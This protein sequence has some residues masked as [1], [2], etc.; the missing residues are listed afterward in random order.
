MKKIKDFIIKNK[1]YIIAFLFMLVI[2]F[3]TPLNGDDWPNYNP[4]TSLKWALSDAIRSYLTYESRIASRFLINILCYNK[5]IWNILNALA[6]S[7]IYWSLTKLFSV[8]NSK[9]YKMFFLLLVM[10]PCGMF[11]QVYTWVTGSIT[12]LF[13]A[14]LIITYFAYSLKVMKKYTFVNTPILIGINLIGGLFIDHCG[15]ALVFINIILILKC[16]KENKKVPWIPIICLGLSIA[17]V[18]IAYFAPGN[19][20]RLSTTSDFAKLGLF[21][22]IFLNYTNFIDY[23]YAVNP[24]L[25]LTMLIPICYM[26]DNVIKKNVILKRLLLI[27]IYII[28]VYS[29]VYHYDLYNPFI[30][31]ISSL[32]F[33]W[34][35]DTLL[36]SVFVYVYWTVI[37][38]LFI[39]SI[40]YININNKKR[41]VYL[42]FLF[43]GLIPNLVML[44]SPT[45][46]FRTT[47]F[48]NIMIGALT[49]SLIF[50]IINNEKYN[51]LDLKIIINVFYYFMIIYLLFIFCVICHFDNVRIEKIREQVESGKNEIIIKACPIRYIWNYNPYMEFHNSAY[52]NYIYYQNLTNNKD[53]TITFTCLE[54]FSD[55]YRGW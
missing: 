30:E 21:S 46:G 29:L 24:I 49:I 37:S 34:K 48:S 43:V 16:I 32:D 39:I 14:A 27:L 12:Y 53:I 36:T 23:I 45:W 7:S 54:Q 17:S 15:A 1:Y 28:P 40:F 26:I 42:M 25:A 4:E 38:I 22:K 11:G 19:V 50:E 52:K 10:I 6:F 51:S 3:L 13:P 20:S 5:I 33:Y 55:V 2:S 18:L 9:Q 8:D 31:Y 41:D 44:L 47:Y 35:S